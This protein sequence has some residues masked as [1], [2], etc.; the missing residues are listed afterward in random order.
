MSLRFIEN[1]ENIMSVGSSGTGK[2]HLATAIGIEATK[3]RKSVY[4]ISCQE[5]RIQLKN[6]QKSKQLNS[7]KTLF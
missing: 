6:M 1:N 4:F 2:T 7:F 3:H 5:L